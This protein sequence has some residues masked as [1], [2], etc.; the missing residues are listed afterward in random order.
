MRLIVDASAWRDLD[1]IG[2]W[3]A[4]DNPDAARRVLIHLLTTIE[5]LG[6]FPRLARPGRVS[7]TYERVVTG[8]PYII[9]F[10]R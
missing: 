7:G 5:Q 9:V 8:M 4:R 6:H 10:E 2:R 3:I 1:D